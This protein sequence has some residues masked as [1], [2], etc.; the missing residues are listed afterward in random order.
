M[1]QALVL[2]ITVTVLGVWVSKVLLELMMRA[3][4]R[5]LRP[6]SSEVVPGYEPA[7][8][9]GQLSADGPMAVN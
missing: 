2:A 5:S 7:A 3:V 8:S 9:P 1:I 6:R 4:D